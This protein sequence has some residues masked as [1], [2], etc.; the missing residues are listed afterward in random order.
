MS[1]LLSDGID[2]R[3]T[4]ASVPPHSGFMMDSV[5]TLVPRRIGSPF[6]QQVE[7][8]S[9]ISQWYGAIC[10]RFV[11]SHAAV[12]ESAPII[13][14]TSSIPTAPIRR[15][16]N[17]FVEQ[18]QSSSFLSSLFE[19][20]SRLFDR[21]SNA[22]QSS[23]QFQSSAVS[24]IC[25]DSDTDLLALV[26]GM[27]GINLRSPSQTHFNEDAYAQSSL[28]HN[29]P[30]QSYHQVQAGL[31]PAQSIVSSSWHGSQDSIYQS[32]QTGLHVDIDVEMRDVS[33]DHQTV[34]RSA[35]K[36]TRNPGFLSFNAHRFNRVK[37]SPHHKVEIVPNWIVR[38]RDIQSRTNE[39]V[40]GFETLRL[41]DSVGWLEEERRTGRM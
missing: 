25:G 40:S 5:V 20:I 24:G 33:S 30:H 34:P 39:P 4:S 35:I 10:S 7:T 12:P 36:G 29:H 3:S 27:Q 16:E 37:F 15:I 32:S 2:S 26:S 11:I 8:D 22:N 38:E 21:G 19:A 1:D 17:V 31:Y 23:D 18:E 6:V 41:E 9:I 13:H 14:Q 28:G